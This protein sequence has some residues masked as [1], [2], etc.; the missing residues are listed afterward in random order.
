MRFLSLSS[1]LVFITLIDMYNVEA[2]L[3]FKAKANM[4][5]VDN[6][7]DVC[8]YSACKHCIEYF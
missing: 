1:F 4:G 3:N 7:L 2:F 5:I 8:L 6:L